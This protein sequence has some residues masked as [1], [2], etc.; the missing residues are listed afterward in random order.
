M[1]ETLRQTAWLQLPRPTTLQDTGYTPMQTTLG[2]S[3]SSR[4]NR[5][6]WDI[7]HTG[8]ILGM[9]WEIHVKLLVQWL[10]YLK[11][12]NKRESLE[13]P[14]VFHFAWTPQGAPTL[15]LGGTA[16]SES[17]SKVLTEY[18]T[19]GSQNYIYRLFFPKMLLLKEGTRSNESFRG[20]G[21]SSK[22]VWGKAYD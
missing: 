8:S 11:G 18:K 19:G 7:L 3:F 14:S 12:S 21:K 20:G 17:V 2:D 9:K 13:S 10:E 5:D 16:G 4:G 15:Q 22:E 1:A 6:T